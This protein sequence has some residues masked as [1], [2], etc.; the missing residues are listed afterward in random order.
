MGLIRKINGSGTEESNSGAPSNVENL[1]RLDVSTIIGEVLE[2]YSDVFPPELPKGVSL[3]AMNS[4]LIWKIR[5]RPSTRH[6]TNSVPL[7]WAKPKSKYKTCS[8]PGL[9][10]PPNPLMVP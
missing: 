1:K 6:Y 4:R 7:S 10:I 9:S 8:N 5:Y 2:H 3:G